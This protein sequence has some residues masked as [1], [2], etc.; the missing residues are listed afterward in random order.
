[1]EAVINATDWGEPVE[2]EAPAKGDIVQ[3]PQM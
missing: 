3:A 1:V 2:V